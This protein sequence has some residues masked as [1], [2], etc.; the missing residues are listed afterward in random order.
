MQL[1]PWHLLWMALQC[2]PFPPSQ[3]HGQVGWCSSCNEGL[4]VQRPAFLV[5]EV[6]RL[7]QFVLFSRK[8]KKKKKKATQKK[9][10]K[11]QRTRNTNDKREMISQTRVFSEICGKSLCMSLKVIR[12]D[13]RIMLIPTQTLCRSLRLVTQIIKDL[14]KQ[15]WLVFSSFKPDVPQPYFH[16]SILYA[17]SEFFYDAVLREFRWLCTPD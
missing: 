13:M 5:G 1:I 7:L 14:D 3:P 4:A 16:D 11:W 6:P 12:A 10:H 2:A 8:K 9:K 17:W 15:R